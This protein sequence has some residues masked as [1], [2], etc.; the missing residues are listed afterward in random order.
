MKTCKKYLK[1]QF[2]AEELKEKSSQLARECRRAEE[3]EDDKKRVMSDFKAKIDALQASISLLSG[4]INNGYEYR[5][6]EC[7][8]ELNVPVAGKKT[9]TRTDNDEQVAVENMDSEE[10]QEKLDFAATEESEDA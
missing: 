10:M 6:I 7:T 3:T 9:I 5:D 4:H 1:Y 8:V 2:T